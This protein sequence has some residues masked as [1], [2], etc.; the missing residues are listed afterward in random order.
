MSLGLGGGCLVGTNPEGNH[1]FV[2]RLQL[3]SHG[4]EELAVPVIDG[5]F[6]L[7]NVSRCHDDA[8][9]VCVCRVNNE[10]GCTPIFLVGSV[11]FADVVGRFVTFAVSIGDEV[12]VVFVIFLFGLQN[13]DADVVEIVFVGLFQHGEVESDGV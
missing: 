3:V 13:K 2:A 8:L 1:V 12:G 10:T 4:D 9:V 5:F 6:T 7:W 11:L